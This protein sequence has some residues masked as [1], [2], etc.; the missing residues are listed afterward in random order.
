M[1]SRHARQACLAGPG[2]DNCGPS[3]ARQTHLYGAVAV[4]VSQDVAA[5][6]Y[7]ARLCILYGLAESARS[8]DGSCQLP[9][10]QIWMA[11][12]AECRVYSFRMHDNI[13]WMAARPENLAIKRSK[14][15]RCEHTNKPLRLAASSQ[16]IS[17]SLV[18]DVG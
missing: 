15:E 17:L 18:M 14:P 3:R 7:L 5:A 11:A 10:M 6:S 16:K 4:N 1:V 8:M 13:S 2:L 9:G 12:A